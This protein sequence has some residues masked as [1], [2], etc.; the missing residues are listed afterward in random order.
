MPQIGLAQHEA[1]VGIGDEEAVAVDDVGLA[2]V[3]DL[4]PR[5]DVPDE[6][7][8]DVGDRHR[9]VV[10]ARAKRN[11]HV[12]LGLLAEV[13]RP[14]PGLAALRVAKR[15]L[16]R[17]VLARIRC[18]PSR[19]ATRAI[20]S[21]PALS[22]CAMSVISGTWRSSFRNSIRRSSTSPAPS[23]GNAAYFELLLD[24]RDV[25]LDARRRRD[26]LLV[27]QARERRLVLLVRKIDADRARREQRDR[28]Q[29]KD[30]Q[31]VF[32]EQAAAVRGRGD[33]PADRRSVA[34]HH[35]G[36]RL[37]R[38]RRPPATESRPSGPDMVRHPT[39]GRP[40]E[41]IVGG[42]RASRF[43]AASATPASL[44]RRFHLRENF[45]RQVEGRVRGRHA[46]VDRAMQQHFADLV[47][48]TPLL[49]AARTCS[50]NSSLRLSAT[51]SP[52]VNRLRVCRGRPGRVQI[53]PHA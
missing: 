32:A 39:R 18:C 7:E 25:L 8:I 40:A 10:A 46:G 19:A 20:C 49:N 4:D 30:Q 35:A 51:I 21:R 13:H 24:R 16:L 2:L 34:E 37:R 22:I 38:H 27:L 36:Q 28:H 53:S 47:A 43:T 44:R 52:I 5:D 6:L 48:V 42:R 23:C 31:Q 41:A 17:A 26:R 11:R 3:A 33:A 14:E 50:L 29:R 1:D 12:R 15:R 45:L 9:P